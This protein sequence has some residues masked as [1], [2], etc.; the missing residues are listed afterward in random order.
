[1]PNRLNIRMVLSAID[2][3]WNIAAIAAKIAAD[4]KD[5]QDDPIVLLIVLNGAFMSAHTWLTR[6]MLV[7]CRA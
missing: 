6:C 4:H 2:L 7:M 5:T 3:K 1:M